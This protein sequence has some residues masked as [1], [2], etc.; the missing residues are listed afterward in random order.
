MALRGL[1]QEFPMRKL[2]CLAAAVICLGVLA[3]GAVAL[4]LACL[5]TSPPRWNSDKRGTRAEERTRS[6]Q[7]AQLEDATRRRMEA[8][9]QVAEEV[10]ARRWS[11]AEAIAQFRT[12]DRQW[13]EYRFRIKNPE[14]LLMSEDER[15]GRGVISYVGEILA[16]HPD[17]AAAV[18][19]S[20][21][22]ELREL[23]AG[24]KTRPPSP[25]DPR[26][27]GSR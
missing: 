7:L 17:E 26:T 1:F 24:R 11:L 25:D 19:G 20:L 4:D 27:T 12:L 22:K 6:G 18:V 15:D 5:L 2:I 14:D 3:L 21:E 23:L 8:K 13:P 9:R 16:G 10:I